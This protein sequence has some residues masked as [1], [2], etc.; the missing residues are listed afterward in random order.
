[1]LFTDGINVDLSP[2]FETYV[3]SSLNRLTLNY[4]KY[5]TTLHLIKFW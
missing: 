1:M 4:Y 2:G 5:E 3:S